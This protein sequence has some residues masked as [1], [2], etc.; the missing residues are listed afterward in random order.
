MCH[1]RKKKAS[2]QATPHRGQLPLSP[3]RRRAKPSARPLPPRAA[4]SPA[5]AP[6]P[7]HCH[8]ATTTVSTSG[9]HLRRT[10]RHRDHR[11]LRLA[12][13]HNHTASAGP[14]GRRLRDHPTPPPPPPL[15]GAAPA[16]PRCAGLFSPSTQCLPAEVELLPQAVAEWWSEDDGC[17]WL[18]PPPPTAIALAST[19]EVTA[20][21]KVIDLEQTIMSD[22]Q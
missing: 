7:R 19:I 14:H 6:P 9:L 17:I 12:R 13:D 18:T 16:P 15:P 8:F 5:R 1:V 22:I 2:R 11:R 3:L 4:T 10:N 20:R 21:T